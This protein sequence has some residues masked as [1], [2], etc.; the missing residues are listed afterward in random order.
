MNCDLNVLILI[1]F[2]V[3]ACA[4]KRVFVFETCICESCSGG[5]QAGTVSLLAVG[6]YSVCIRIAFRF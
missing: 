3:Y 2:N 6:D 4:C 5:L 1:R